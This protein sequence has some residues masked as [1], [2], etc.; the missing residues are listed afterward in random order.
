MSRE[1]YENEVYRLTYKWRNDEDFRAKQIKYTKSGKW[2]NFKEQKQFTQA[3]FCRGTARGYTQIMERIYRGEL[4]SPV[5]SKI[6]REYLE[7][8]MQLAGEQQEV[9]VYGVKNGSLP[10]VI[11]E[12]SYLKLKNA[13]NARVFALFFENLPGAIWFEMLQ[14]YIQQDFGYLLLGDDK[15]F[16]LVRQSLS[17]IRSE[18]LIVKN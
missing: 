3:L 7:W 4:F 6:M 1:D 18:K 11:T 8:S 2:L 9:D 15:F 16:Q 17:K 10:G 13:K 12:V 14:N 5:A